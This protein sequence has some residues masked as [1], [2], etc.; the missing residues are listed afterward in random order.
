MA[1]NGGGGG[2]ETAEQRFQ[3]N[4][5]GEG[6][7]PM[8]ELIQLYD[9]TMASRAASGSHQTGSDAR[10][11]AVTRRTA[12]GNEDVMTSPERSACGMMD[13]DSMNSG[14]KK[15]VCHI[16]PFVGEY[17]EALSSSSL[18]FIAGLSAL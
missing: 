6:R 1:A 17:F 18:L 5:T 8:S 4:N 10:P 3:I 13:E 12:D 15:Y 16:C 11:T 14:A 7:C 2:V 9:V